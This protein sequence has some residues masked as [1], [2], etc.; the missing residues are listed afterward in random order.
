MTYS[1]GQLLHLI[2][3]I[4][5]NLCITEVG[6]VINVYY[7]PFIRELDDSHVGHGLAVA[8]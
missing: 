2:P 7:A 3:L 1:S 6:V 4:N 8:P 5:L